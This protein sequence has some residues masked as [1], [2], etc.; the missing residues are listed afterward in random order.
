MDLSQTVAA[1]TPVR[2]A[3]RDL[4]VVPLTLRQWGALQG[5]LKGAA[6]DPIERALAAIERE[7]A[8]GRA[9]A[10][11]A[12]KWLYEQAYEEARAWP[13]QVGSPRWFD[14]LD[15]LDEGN[16][17]LVQAIFAAAGAD[18]SVEECWALTRVATL[19][20]TVLLLHAAYF[21]G[22]PVPKSTA[23]AAANGDGRGPT[24]PPPTTGAKWSASSAPGTDGPTIRLLK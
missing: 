13:P 12:T 15:R 6:P 18:L 17:R 16:A 4:N 3:G 23:P 2:Y 1:P 20:E 21:G 8:A 14:A 5:W 22:R 24:P 19:D 7:T 9:P 10:P 11:A